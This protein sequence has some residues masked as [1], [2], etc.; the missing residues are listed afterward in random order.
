[1]NLFMYQDARGNE[2]YYVGRIISFVCVLMVVFIGALMAIIPPY[3][4][5]TKELSGKAMLKEAEWQKR[6]LVEEA[7]AEKD[8]A[9]LYADAEIERA[10]ESAMAAPDPAPEDALDDVF[11]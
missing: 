7:I 2:Q 5:W 1:M 8:A 9:V 3:N 4:V 11:A 10:V 6:V